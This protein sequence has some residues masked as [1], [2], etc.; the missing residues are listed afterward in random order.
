MYELPFAKGLQYQHSIICMEGGNCYFIATP[1]ELLA[2]K[3][4]FESILTNG[5]QI[6]DDLID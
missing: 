5:I 6:D 1:E 2:N 4:E 3:L